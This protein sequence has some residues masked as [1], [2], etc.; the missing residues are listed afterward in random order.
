MNERFIS[1]FSKFNIKDRFLSDSNFNV[2]TE[3]YKLTNIIL[4][5]F[6]VLKKDNYPKGA[7]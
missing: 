5:S 4:P 7:L 3:N 6:L 1:L 2:L